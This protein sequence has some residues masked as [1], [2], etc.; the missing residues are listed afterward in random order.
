MDMNKQDMHMDHSMKMDHHMNM[1]HD[2]MMDMG[3]GHM[4]HMDNFKRRFWI[5]LILAIPILLLSPFMGIVLPFQL[6][7]PGSQWVVLVL[8][9]ILFFYGGQP[10]F[11]GAKEELKAK[12]PAMMTLISM[13][14]SVAYIYSVYSFIMNTL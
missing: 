2:D 3:G 6:T 12:A 11:S 5:S 10:F 9:T 7:F 13:G 1:K 8:A 4:M 14:I